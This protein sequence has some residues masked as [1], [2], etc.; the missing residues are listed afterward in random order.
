[1]NPLDILRTTFGFPSFRGV[2]PQVVDR[3]MAG[4][5]TLAVMP[6]GA[7]LIKLTSPFCSA[8]MLVLVSAIKRKVA[9]CSGGSSPQ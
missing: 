9:D 1:M 3:V 2:Q 6:T 4:Q 5:H 7:G 8:V